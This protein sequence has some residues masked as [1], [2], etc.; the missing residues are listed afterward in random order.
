MARDQLMVQEIEQTKNEINQLKN[1]ISNLRARRQALA[2]QPTIPLGHGLANS[3]KSFLPNHLVPRNVGSLNSAAWNFFYTTDFDLST[4]VDWPNI[5]SNT[6][7]TKT[8]QVSQEAAFLFMGVMRH[9]DDYNDA[10][11][12]G[13]LTIEFRDKQSSRFF[14]DN[15]IPL[16]MFGKQGYMTYLPVP[17]LIMPNAF[18]EITMS[19]FLDPGVV[20]NTPPASSGKHQITMQGYR[21]RI[22][23]AHKVL[24]SVFSAGR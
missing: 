14:N 17:M 11:D 20:Q 3:L 10:G 24:S 13:P 16:Q 18:F 9:A 23:D 8:F 6:K 15:P 1:T 4:T 2:S 12:L 5:T 7:Q 19:T 22:E 21:I